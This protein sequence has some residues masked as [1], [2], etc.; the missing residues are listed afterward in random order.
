[1]QIQLNTS[2]G[3]ENKESLDRWADEELRQQL[4]RYADDLT[5]VEVHLSDVDQREQWRR[6]SVIADVVSHRVTGQGPDGY[7]LALEWVAARPA[8]A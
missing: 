6:A 8:P 5:R 2:N 7:R 4:H 3:V 1:M